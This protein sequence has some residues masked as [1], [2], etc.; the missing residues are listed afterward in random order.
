MALIDL[1]TGKVKGRHSFRNPQLA[2]G[3]D[4][5]SRINAANNGSLEE[6]NFLITESIT[7]GVEFLLQ[8][9]GI[10]KIEESVIAGNTT[11]TYLLLALP[12]ESL[13]VFPFKPIYSFENCNVA[14]NRLFNFPADIMPWFSA[15]VGG[16]I[17]AGLLYVLPEEKQRFMLI[18]LGTNGEMALYDNGKL[19]VTSTAAGQVFENGHKGASAVIKDLACLVRTAMID[20]TGLLKQETVLTQ[21][22]V[23]DLQL[24]KSAVRSGLE[25]LL[26]NSKLDYDS[27]DVVYLA[28]GIGQAMDAEDAADIGLI[29]GELSGK[30]HA[31]GNASLGGAV[32][33]LLCP[34]RTTDDIQNLL[35]VFEE[36]NLAAHPNFNDLFMENMSFE[37]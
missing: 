22:Q 28:G 19:H 10:H 25:I 7:C 20:E 18:D 13:G 12:C 31:V 34:S 5:I 15:F 37:V 14:S 29:P 11:M 16:D 36:I 24:A 26:E 9:C 32:R 35:S 2:V 23:R 4:V 3:P 33:R 8:S 1:S 21:K 30:I 6:L 17:T 27:L